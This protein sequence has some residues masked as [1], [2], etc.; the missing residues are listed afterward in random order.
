MEA[1]NTDQETYIIEIEHF[2]K[3]E[4]T[5][6][7]IFFALD[8]LKTELSPDIRFNILSAFVI[9]DKDFLIDIIDYLNA[10]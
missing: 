8:T 4:M 7:N 6:S 5:S 10:N 3:F 2:G 9:K 1:E